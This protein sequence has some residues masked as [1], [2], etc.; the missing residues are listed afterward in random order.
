MSADERFE[1][2]IARETIG[3][4]QA[5]ASGLADGIEA[6]DFGF[7]IHVG[8]HAA[9]LVMGGG[10]DRDRRFGNIYAVA[11]AGLMNVG[12]AFADEGG[13]LMRDVEQDARRAAFFHLAINGARD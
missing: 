7:A 1:Q 8:E 2:G 11:K 12:K 9:A 10:H 6:G 4:V 13:W 5:G 3:A